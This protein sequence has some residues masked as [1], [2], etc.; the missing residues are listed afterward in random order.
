MIAVIA[1]F[2]ILGQFEYKVKETRNQY[3]MPYA[4]FSIL[5][6]ILYIV[7]WTG[8]RNR[9][10]DTA[11]Y[12]A[13]Y[14]SIPTGN[15]ETIK[16]YMAS[17]E[18]DYGFY[19]LT[20]LFKNYI[21]TNYHWWLFTIA[22]ISGLCLY[23]VIRRHAEH[24]HFALYLFMTTCTFSW[25]MNG[26]RQFIVICIL[27]AFSDWMLDKK[28]R[29]WYFVLI[30]AVSTIHMSALY[31][32]P[33]IIVVS[34]SR[35][36]DKKM[37]MFIASILFVMLFSEKIMPGLINS[38]ADDYATTYATNEG[39]SWIRTL[40]A[41]V[42]VGLTFIKRK[43]IQKF[44]NPYMEMCVNMSIVSACIYGLASVSD[45]ILVGR[46]PMFFQVYNLILLPW[47]LSKCYK[48]STRKFLIAA[49]VGCYLLFF[50]Y[51]THFVGGYYYSSDI[52]GFIP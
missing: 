12:I 38:F 40:V 15:L 8:I 51:Q 1:I 42:P 47:V 34:I 9:F 28:K 13:T 19:L 17:I 7:F 27:F 45:G 48:G 43:E 14:K 41:I 44:N 25:L 21:S 10:V 6:P 22:L 23:R 24:P 26:I 29:K 46:M 49:C 3:G 2:A 5:I 18:E 16:L 36:W 20:A 33:F 32:L 50:I 11:A 52:T 4:S 37:L 35:A 30:L 31:A 39:S